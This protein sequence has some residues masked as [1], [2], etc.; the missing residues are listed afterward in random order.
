M[1]DIFTPIERKLHY[2]EDGDRLIIESIQDVEPVLNRNRELQKDKSKTR[3][4]EMWWVA[5]IPN[6]VIE[7]WM[8]EGINIFKKEDWPKVKARLN[9]PNYRYLR[10]DMANI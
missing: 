10:T 5:S 8:K 7:Q 3:G 1:A 2:N 9:D 4:K 6:I